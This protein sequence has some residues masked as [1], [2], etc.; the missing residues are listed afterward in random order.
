M[1]E[2]GRKVL[3]EYK[4]AIIKEAERWLLWG[5]PIPVF[6]VVAADQELPAIS[7]IESRNLA[8]PDASEKVVPLDYRLVSKDIRK[9]FPELA[10]DFRTAPSR[11]Y[12]IAIVQG[13]ASAEFARIDLGHNETLIDAVDREKLKTMTEALVKVRQSTAHEK[14]ESDRRNSLQQSI[15]LLLIDL[16]QRPPS[17]DEIERVLGSL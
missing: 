4:S 9:R 14:H 10:E 16:L 5:R 12:A 17:N 15:E 1:N 7:L 6:F 2:E 11:R 13:K 3:E 8:A